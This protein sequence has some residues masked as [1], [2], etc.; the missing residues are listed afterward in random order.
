MKEK[1]TKRDIYQQVTNRIVA[2]LEQGCAP[3][4]K[5]WADGGSTTD[6]PINGHSKRAYRGVN[7]LLLWLTQAVSGFASGEWFTFKQALQ[8]GGK[9]R[10]GEKATM[11][12]FW[13]QIDVE[14]DES[15]EP[16][17]TKTPTPASW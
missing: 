16:G 9:V 11:V 4:V 6:I 10:R 14:D 8:A 3:W 2:E 5:P 7:T 15:E 17:A 13:K 12:V 1:S